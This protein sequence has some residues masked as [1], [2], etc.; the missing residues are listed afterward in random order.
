MSK[1]MT[2][3]FKD[4]HFY[5]CSNALSKAVG[6]VTDNSCYFTENGLL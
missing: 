1:T 4:F 6:N 5:Y 3:I 2:F